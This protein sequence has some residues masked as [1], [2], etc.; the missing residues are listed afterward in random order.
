MASNFLLHHT[1]KEAKIELHIAKGLPDTKLG[2]MTNVTNYATNQKPS[3]K[4]KLST[5]KPE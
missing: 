3:K 4:Y 2:R 5:G 1:T